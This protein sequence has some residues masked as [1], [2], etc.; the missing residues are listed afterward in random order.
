MRI[1]LDIEAISLSP[2]EPRYVMLC[3]PMTL[4]FAVYRTTPLDITELTTPRDE[5]WLRHAI[6]DLDDVA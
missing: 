2:L 5:A 4:F 6:A 1:L 3:Y